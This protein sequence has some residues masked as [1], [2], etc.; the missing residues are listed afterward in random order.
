M[1]NRHIV[2]APRPMSVFNLN[3]EYSNE[4]YGPR[5]F[6]LVTFLTLTFVTVTSIRSRAFPF[7]RARSHATLFKRNR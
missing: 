2:N 7:L 4:A 5:P 3:G 6:T 1:V